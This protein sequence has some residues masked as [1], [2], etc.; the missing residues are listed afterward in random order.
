MSLRIDGGATPPISRDEQ[1]RLVPSRIDADFTGGTPPAYRI[2]VCNDGNFKGCAGSPGTWEV[3]LVFTPPDW[4]WVASP[5]DSRPQAGVGLAGE[6]NTDSPLLVINVNNEEY[7]IKSVFVIDDEFHAMGLTVSPPGQSERNQCGSSANRA[8]HG[9]RDHSESHRLRCQFLHKALEVFLRPVGKR[10]PVQVGPVSIL[11]MN[12]VGHSPIA[13]LAT[14]HVSERL[15]FAFGIGG[16][17]YEGTRRSRGTG[18]RRRRLA[19]PGRDRDRGG[20]G[21]RSASGGRPAARRPR[22]C[23]RN[24]PPDRS[25]P[26]RLSDCPGARGNSIHAAAGRRCGRGDAT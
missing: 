8:G 25:L 23:G 7:D 16:L 2:T 4:F 24:P 19:L 20:D 17:S 10:K 18:R 5:E 11:H 26:G 1:A 6:T 12:V 13:F 14:R 9:L 21:R 15:R 22:G 3:L